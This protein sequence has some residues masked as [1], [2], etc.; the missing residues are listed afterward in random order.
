LLLLYF[1]LFSI[2]PPWIFLVVALSVSTVLENRGFKIIRDD[3][4]MFRVRVALIEMNEPAIAFMAET[5]TVA[6][7]FA[8]SFGL[9]HFG[10]SS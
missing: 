4:V 9:I 7:E 2:L 8:N 1:H 6:P 10:S 5:P 3:V